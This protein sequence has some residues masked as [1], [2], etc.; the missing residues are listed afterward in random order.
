VA[1]DQQALKTV[2]GARV[3]SELRLL[4]REPDP[5][6]ALEALKHYDLD[7]AI[8]PGLRLTD[9]GLARKALALLPDDG[10]PDLLAI[11]VATS[12]LQPDH[13]RKLLDELAF[14]AGDRDTIVAAGTAADQLAEALSEA[15]ARSAI[16]DA[17]RG[18]PPELVALAGALGPAEQA[19]AWLTELRHVRLEIDG[20][21]L[22][23]AGVPEGPEVGAGLDR[24]LR[25]K[26]DRRAIDRD[27]E[28]A[29]ALSAAR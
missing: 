2:S 26:L 18:K 11:A 24:A 25:A 15:K 14:E 20:R 17:A 27:A 10:R 5:V 28:L 19:T 21:D 23:A 13:L 12:G 6:T 9:P 4:A 16:A 3:G 7:H 8:D 22:I 29:E 1:L